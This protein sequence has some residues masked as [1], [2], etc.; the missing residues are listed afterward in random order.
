MIIP[1]PYPYPHR[2]RS[3]STTLFGERWNWTQYQICTGHW[4]V[5]IYGL[6]TKNRHPL[7]ITDCKKTVSS[8]VLF[9]QTRTQTTWLPPSWNEGKFFLDILVFILTAFG[10]A[11]CA[12]VIVGYLENPLGLL[13]SSVAD[14]ECFLSRIQIFPIQVAGSASI[15]LSILTQKPVSKLSEIWSG[16]FIPPDPDPDFF[17]HL[18]SRI[19]GSKRHRIPGPD[20]LYC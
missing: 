19:Q 16:L 15:N 8:H 5:V 3:G 12:I 11:I 6:P 2:R 13:K 7:S 9:K 17:T 10:S 14:P 18:G 4:D 20:P 1:D